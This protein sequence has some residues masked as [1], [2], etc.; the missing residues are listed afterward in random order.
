MWSLHTVELE[1]LV[2]VEGSASVV[3]VEDGSSLDCTF[4][5]SYI[6]LENNAGRIKITSTQ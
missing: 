4:A 6:R 3:D 5:F 1:V 2:E